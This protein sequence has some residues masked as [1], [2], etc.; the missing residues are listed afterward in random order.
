MKCTAIRIAGMPMIVCGN[1]KLRACSVCRDPAGRLC[2]WKLPDGS[3]CDKPLCDACTTRPA[4]EKDLCP[5]HAKAWAADPRNPSK[6]R[7]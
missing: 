2:D 4:P 1:K 3:T 6:A 7:A 5:E